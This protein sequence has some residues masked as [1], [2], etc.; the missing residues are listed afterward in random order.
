MIRVE[1][2]YSHLA[3]GLLQRNNAPTSGFQTEKTPKHRGGV[4]M[5][6]YQVPRRSRSRCVLLAIGAAA[7]CLMGCAVV[8]TQSATDAGEGE[9]GQSGQ[10]GLPGDPCNDER[11]CVTEICV[12]DL[13]RAGAS[14]DP[15]NDDGDCAGATPLCG[16]GETGCQSGIEGQDCDSPSDCAEGAPICA[17]TNVCQGGTQG[18]PCND[19]GDC[20]D[21]ICVGELCRAGIGGDPCIDDDDC[22][23]P[24][25]YCVDDDGAG[26]NAPECQSGVEGEPCVDKDDCAPAARLCSS[27]NICQDGTSGDG[28]GE[29]G[30]CAAPSA[31]C[32]PDAICQ[33][34]LSTDPCDDERDCS[35]TAPH[36]WEETCHRGY[37][38]GVA[39]RYESEC[40][41]GHCSN[42]ICPPVIRLG[43]DG[44]IAMPFAYIPAGSFWM[45]S[46][47][48]CPGPEEYPGD[49]AL[50]PGHGVDEKLHHVKLTVP[51]Y[52]AETEV[53]QEQWSALVETNPSEFNEC[54]HC[55]VENVSWWD[56]VA[57]VNALSVSEGLE[58][59]YTLEG[60]IV[61]ISD[62]GASGKPVLCEGYRLPTEAEWEYAYRART[63][64]ASYR[65]VVTDA[66]C[67]LDSSLNLI[68]W[69]CGNSEVIHENCVDLSDSG[70]PEC[71]RTRPVGEKRPNGWGLY[72]MSGNV[73][74]WI[75]DW[76]QSDYYSSSPLEDPLGGTTGTARVYRGGGFSSD[77]FRCRAAYRSG[78]GPGNRGYFLGFRPAR[79][80]L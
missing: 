37:P 20:W 13:C 62:P 50:E 60:P 38:V 76:Y 32:G 45:G 42:G 4:E 27:F 70:G 78:S 33:A 15:C 69:Y 44:D 31:L 18:D 54:E 11:D 9:T 67:S 23:P 14:G 57:Y 72:D 8:E 66:E 47:D 6:R 16:P 68:G 30:D 7:L 40:E 25:P 79:S 17:S 41:S 64:T 36:C 46:P 10:L 77:A 53:T 65:G 29:D 1:N 80:A 34:G 49:C 61:T 59:C 51:F 3:L 26:P 2:D 19:D 52:L 74:E 75:W 5:A 35:T 43:E 39:C 63:T 12:A 21:E 55:P 48:G 22:V 28:C 56:A 71:A 73:D 58:P 24:T